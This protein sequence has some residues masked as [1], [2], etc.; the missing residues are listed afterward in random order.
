MK[1]VWQILIASVL[2]R[3]D[4]LATLLQRLQPGLDRFD[5][6]VQVL[7][8]RDDCER[9]VG[10]K[11]SWLL[12]HAAADY[13][14]FVDDDDRVAASYIDR[15]MDALE[16]RPDYVGFRVAYSV[17]GTLQKPVIHSLR[18]PRWSEDDHGYYRGVSHLNP[19]R[20]DA[21]LAGLPFL[22]GFGEDSDW[23]ARVDA[24]GLVQTEVFIDAPMYFY[25]FSTS[26]S[27]FRDGSRRPVG[28]AV[29][30]PQFDHVAYL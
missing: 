7:I 14:C 5:G 30:A 23:A 12:G 13:V 24:S 3:T 27:L 2:A 6:H 9:E 22:P 21:A 26:G 16:D 25:D 10:A 29:L 8:D 20:R 1:P 15:I 19:I 28:H 18:Y 17:D 4:L 11:R